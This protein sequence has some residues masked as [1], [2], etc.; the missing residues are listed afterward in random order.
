TVHNDTGPIFGYV[1]A[2]IA[3]AQFEDALEVYRQ[4]SERL[5]AADSAK[6]LESLHS[7]IGHVREN[8]AALEKLLELLQKAGENT[9]LTELYELLAHAYVQSGELE[10]ARDYYLNLTQL[11]PQNQLH[12]RN[13]QQV[14]ARL[15]G[16]S[17]SRLITAEEGA[18]LVDELEATAPFVDQRYPDEIALAVR[19]A[20][21]DAE[22]FV[23]YNMP[24]KALGPLLSALPKAPSD[25]RLNQRLAALHT[26]ASR[27][28]EA[29]VCCRILESI[30]HDAG[31]PDE[32]TRYGE[33][34]GK[35][36]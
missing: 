18:V 12:T 25:L 15:G 16:T 2:L 35:Y 22:L 5:L 27:F 31:H 20:L 8:P 4:H 32:A 33:L 11:E 23:S 30:Y 9:H 24:P 13:Y 6:V 1:D 36:E 21:T 34:A 29:A 3:A 10:K 26:R 14:V 17:N 19:A 7:L 28:A